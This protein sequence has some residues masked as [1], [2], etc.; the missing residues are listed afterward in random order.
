VVALLLLPPT[1]KA[2]EREPG[3]LFE[4]LSSSH[5]APYCPGT[6]PAY[7]NYLNMPFDCWFMFRYTFTIVVVV[8]TS[9]RLRKG[10]LATAHLLTTMHLVVLAF[11]CRR[12]SF[13]Y[14]LQ[15][16]FVPGNAFAVVVVVLA[17]S[18]QVL[19]S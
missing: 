16:C 13:E 17:A 11:S 6:F 2:V 9:R 19:A 15:P 14:V 1:E 7:A 10:W 5:N 12:K 4:R 8:I 18:D 3:S